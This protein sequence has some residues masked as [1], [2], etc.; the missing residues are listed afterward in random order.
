MGKF[1]ATLACAR[2][3]RAPFVCVAAGDSDTCV[4]HEGFSVCGGQCWHVNNTASLNYTQAQDYCSSLGARLAL[5]A[6][7]TEHDCAFCIMDIA[8]AWFLD[9]TWLGITGGSTLESF[10][11]P[12]GPLQYTRWEIQTLKECSSWGCDNCATL[13]STGRWHVEKCSS[14]SFPMCQR[15]CAAPTPLEC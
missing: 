14:S 8:L 11:G 2:L 1:I 6:N 13:A 12:D 10:E 15:E 9:T 3:S 4:C 5:P 7:V